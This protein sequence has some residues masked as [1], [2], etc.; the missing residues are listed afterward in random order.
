MAKTELDLQQ[1]SEYQKHPLSA[2]A[3]DMLDGTRESLMEARVGASVAVQ[4][5]SAVIISATNLTE[6]VLLRIYPKGLLKAVKLPT[7]EAKIT[8]RLGKLGVN[9]KLKN[10]YPEKLPNTLG[11]FVGII[12]ELLRPPKKD[13]RTYSGF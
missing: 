4:D 12:G 1:Y 9:E 7:Q 2:T 5:G 3:N 8:L 13:P 6:A 11:G 10:I